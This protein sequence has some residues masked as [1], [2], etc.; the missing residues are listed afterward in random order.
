M[1]RFRF[2]ICIL[3]ASAAVLLAGCTKP[4][5]KPQTS[6]TTTAAD[7]P[8]ASDAALLDAVKKAL[9]A[10]TALATEKIQVSV[11]DGRVT[12]VGKV[13]KPENRLRAEDLARGVPEVFG[14]DAERLVAQ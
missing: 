10:D 7:K 2:V 13:T 14:V 8:A 3:T 5:G 12:L 1:S 6:E 9:A 11:K 4:E